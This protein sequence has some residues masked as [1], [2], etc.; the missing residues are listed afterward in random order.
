MA[1]Y[2]LLTLSF[3]ILDPSR[4]LGFFREALE[5]RYGRALRHALDRAGLNTKGSYRIRAGRFDQLPCIRALFYPPRAIS[6][7]EAR[8]ISRGKLSP[9]ECCERTITRAPSGVY[10]RR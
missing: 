2:I 9:S 8:R 3:G 1:K 10:Q 6:W 5:V 7:L 4:F